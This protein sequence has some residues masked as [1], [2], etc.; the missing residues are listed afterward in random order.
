MSKSVE[1]TTS[2]RAFTVNLPDISSVI[3]QLE[4]TKEGVKEGSVEYN[5]IYTDEVATVEAILADLT[6]LQEMMSA[7]E[8]DPTIL[9]THIDAIRKKKNGGFWRQ[10][11]TDVLIAENCTEYFTEFTNA[12]SA[13]LLRLDVEDENT[14][15]FDLRTRTYTF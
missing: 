13:L 11:G 2:G 4:R 6:H 5:V 7:V 9:T 8:A 3:E 10:S 15:T 1:V 14:C 12:W